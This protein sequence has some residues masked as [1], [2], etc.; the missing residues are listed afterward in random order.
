MVGVEVFFFFSAQQQGLLQQTTGSPEKGNT[1]TANPAQALRSLFTCL[2]CVGEGHTL[3][4]LLTS[5]I[6]LQLCLDSVM[7]CFTIGLNINYSPT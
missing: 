5:K 4:S 6:P 7:A 3:T 2:E 1:I